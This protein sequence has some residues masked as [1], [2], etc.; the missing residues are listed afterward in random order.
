MAPAPAKTPD[1]KGK[2][3]SRRPRGDGS[4]LII[5]MEAAR[6]AI[7]GFLVVGRLL[8][9]FQVSPRI[10]VDKL[11]ASSAWR[12]QGTVIGQE[13]ASDD[14]RFVLNFSAEEDRRF[15]LKAR[16]WHYKRGGIIFVGID[17][18]GNPV[19]VDLGAMA[20]WVQVCDLP[21]ELKF[22]SMGWS[23]GDQLGDVISL[24]HRNHMIVEKYLRLRVEIPL[25]EPL[26]SVVEFTLLVVLR[27][28][29]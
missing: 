6:R 12:L 20:I 23:F 7:S 14:G 18:K 29:V 21:F 10:I 25:H 24:F 2:S 17:G 11:R 13:V 9:P 27:N 8:S 19:E 28:E 16:S 15:V 22:E 26:K 5:D 3:T 4:A 1:S